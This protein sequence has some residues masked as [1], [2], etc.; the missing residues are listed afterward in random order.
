M[1]ILDVIPT[2]KIPKGVSQVLSYFSK[3]ELKAGALVLV[4]LG[5]SKVNALVVSS[6]PLDGEKINI[7]RS[8]FQMKNIDKIISKE[9]LLSELQ[10]KLFLWFLKYYSSPVGLSAKT[11]LPSYVV[12]RRTEIK[13][14]EN[15]S[16]EINKSDIKKNI[17]IFGEK[18]ENYYKK[19]IKK[20]L[21]EKKQVLFLVPDVFSLEYYSDIFS[22]FNPVV[23]S[24]K[25]SPKKYFDIYKSVRND[26]IK[27]VISTRMGVFLNFAK[28][29]LLVFDQENDQ[30]YKSRNMMPYYHAKDIALKLAELFSAKFVYGSAIPSIET[31][32]LSK[33]KKID[34]IHLETEAPKKLPMLIDMRNEIFGGNYSILSWQLQNDIENILEKKEQ[35]LF[36]ISRKGAETFVFCR[37]CGY[38]EK[39]PNC[40]SSLIHHRESNMSLL[41][42]HQCG[43]K[44][45]VQLKCPA[46][47]SHRIKYFGAGTQKAKEEVLKL[48]PKARVGILDSDVTP[49]QKDQKKVFLDFKNKKI[50]ILIGTQL[51]FK[52]QELKKVNL[53]AILSLDNLLHIPD[54]RSGERIFSILKNISSFCKNKGKLYLQTYTQENQVLELAAKLD[55]DKFY[56]SEISARELFSY[57]PFAKLIKFIYK[58]KNKNLAESE[59]VRLSE[60]FKKLDMSNIQILGPAPAYIPKVR[61]EYIFQIIVKIKISDD[62]ENKKSILLKNIPEGWIIDVDPSSLL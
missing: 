41:L 62:F 25:L 23:V 9:P 61:N 50:D 33:I 49:T 30:A 52:K 2:V 42:C 7:R 13:N 12:K 27:L 22:E 60:K 40:E 26:D 8:Q 59:A 56:K 51:L 1:Y 11:F 21:K 36:F 58:N 53:V 34:I 57:P 15:I 38:V 44:K 10:I 54:F 14:I 29:G 48:F 55:Y 35:A 5:R 16:I 47:Q 37:D 32:W 28:L 24:S 20:V 17:L 18:R 3:D 43:F 4:P 19:E 46:C 39:C 45:E 31:Y 6:Y